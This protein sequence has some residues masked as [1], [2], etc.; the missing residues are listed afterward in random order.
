MTKKHYRKLARIMAEGRL[1]NNA[2]FQPWT[3][4]RKEMS[5]Q[6]KHIQSEL[7]E[8][9]AADNPNFNRKLFDAAC[10]EEIG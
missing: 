9:L 10:R 7:A 1:F 8:F 2:G 4:A 5:S 3:E 6:W